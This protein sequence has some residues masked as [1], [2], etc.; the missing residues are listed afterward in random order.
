MEVTDVVEKNGESVVTATV[1]GN[2]E[3]DLVSLDFHFTVENQKIT[4]LRI[5]SAGK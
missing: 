1:S 5:V 3:G 4:A 2:F